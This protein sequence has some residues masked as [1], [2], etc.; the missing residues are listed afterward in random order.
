MS[1]FAVS[2][3]QG[4]MSPPPPSTR[5]RTS[6]L[7][8]LLT[9][10]QRDITDRVQWARDVQGHIDTSNRQSRWGQATAIPQSFSRIPTTLPNNEKDNEGPDAVMKSALPGQAGPPVADL[11][12]NFTYGV[13]VYI[14]GALTFVTA[15]AWRD[16]L[17]RYFNEKHSLRNYGPWAGA[18]IITGVAVIL[19]LFLSQV[20]H[21]IRTR[22]EIPLARE[23]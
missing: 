3:V 15:L 6:E 23:I 16:A 2:E 14:L 18:L 20:K 8:S 9:M 22:F 1:T 19:V 10:P 13:V 11:G 21:R 17:N 5:H 7:V 12:V 4:A